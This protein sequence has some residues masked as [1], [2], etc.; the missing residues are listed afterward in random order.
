[1]SSGISSFFSTLFPVI[2]CEGM[3][4]EKEPKPEAE[5]EEAEEPEDETTAP[6]LFNKLR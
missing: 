5:E 2:Q 6:K 1:M 4:S 3:E